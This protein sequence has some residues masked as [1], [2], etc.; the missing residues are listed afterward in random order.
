MTSF[1]QLISNQC[2]HLV[3]WISLLSLVLSCLWKLN[4]LFWSH[5]RFILMSNLVLI[6]DLIISMLIIKW[7]SELNRKFPC[8]ALLSVA[9]ASTPITVLFFWAILSWA[10]SIYAMWNSYWLRLVMGLWLNDWWCRDETESLL[11]C[12]HGWAARH[13]LV[14]RLIVVIRYETILR[15]YLLWIFSQ[16]DRC[17]LS[18][19]RDNLSKS[20]FSILSDTLS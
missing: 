10:P 4:N 17:I 9:S 16:S 8:D 14:S 3:Q 1:C 15:R 11:W 20:I 13:A 19:C 18:R 6:S 7:F 12:T 5:G 2:I